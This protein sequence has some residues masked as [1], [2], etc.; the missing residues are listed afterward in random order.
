MTR[1]DLIWSAAFGAAFAARMELHGTHTSSVR[2]DPMGTA[3]GGLVHVRRDRGVSRSGRL[4][5]HVRRAGLATG[6]L[7]PPDHATRHAGRDAKEA[8]MTKDQQHDR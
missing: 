1:R 7:A 5:A 2:D 4:L 3:R 6:R 8:T